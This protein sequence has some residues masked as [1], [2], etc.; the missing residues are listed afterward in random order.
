MKKLK[1]IVNTIIFFTIILLLFNN[2]TTLHSAEEKFKHEKT[3]TYVDNRLLSINEAY[4]KALRKNIADHEKQEKDIPISIHSN[5][6][7]IA[8]ST[9]NQTNGMRQGSWDFDTHSGTLTIHEG[10]LENG[11]RIKNWVAEDIQHIFLDGPLVAAADSSYLFHDL[12]LITTLDL[13][14]L[15]TSNVTTMFSMFGKASSLSNIDVGGWD[16]S[17]VTVMEDMF[18][19]TSSLKSVNVSGWDTSN[20]TT[21]SFMFDGASSLEALD[22]SKWNTSK[23]ES[24]EDMFY[25]NAALTTLDVSNWDVSN[26]IIMEDMFYQASSLTNLN[27]SNWKPSKVITM[28]YMF[29][30]TSSLE[31][32]DVQHWDTAN[33]R[34]MSDM[35]NGASKLTSLDVSH[36]NT[37]NITDF[38]YMFND[39]S[40]LTN[41]NVS[42]WDISNATNME[43]IFYGLDN[44][45]SLDVSDW[46][47]VNLT[48][49]ERMFYQL[50]NLVN[51]NMTG[52]NTSEIV[53]MSYM[54]DGANSLVNLD[55]SGWDTSSVENMS[56]MFYG[57]SSL[58]NLDVGN[59]NTSKVNDMSYLFHGAS[60]LMSLDVSDW[61]ISNVTNLKSIFFDLHE[62][63]SLDVSGWNTSKVMDMEDMFYNASSLITL[64]VDSWNTANVNNMSFMFDGASGLTSLDVSHWDTSNVTDMEDMFFGN[65]SL[66]HLDVSDWDTSNVIDMED[67]FYKNSSLTSLDVTNWNTSKVS[68]MSYMFGDTKKLESLDLSNWNTSKVEDISGIFSNTNRLWKIT[69][70]PNFK[71]HNI[72]AKFQEAPIKGTP[73]YINDTTVDYYAAGTRNWQAI[74]EGS[75]H[76]PAGEKLTAEQLMETYLLTGPANTTTYVWEQMEP[77]QFIIGTDFVMYIGDPIPVVDDFNAAATN[78]IGQKIDVYIDLST[79][80]F[81]T[82]GEYTVRLYTDDGQEMSVKLS[83]KSSRQS[84]TANNFKMYVGND[85]PTVDDFN[86]KATD[87]RGKRLD[88][89]ADFSEANFNVPGEYPIRLYTADDQTLSVKLIVKANQ[90]SITAENFSMYVGDDAPTVADFKAK[91]TDIDGKPI[92]V[93]LDLLDADINVPGEY[94]IR[95]YTADDQTL[96]VK[97]I[98]KANQKSITAENFSMYVGDDVPTV[99]DFK[100]KATDIDG[101]LITVSLDL[102]GA[103]INVPGEYPI[104]LYTAD[105]QTLSVK[106]IVKAKKTIA[107]EDFLM[108]IGDKAP[109]VEDFKAKATNIKGDAIKV[110]LDLSGAKLDTPGEYRVRLYTEDNQEF[111]VKLT[112]MKDQRM[113]FGTDLTITLGNKKP[114]ISDFAVVAKNKFGNNIKIKADWSNVDFSKAGRYMVLFTTDDGQS[115][116]LILNIEN[117]EIND[118]IKTGIDDEINSYFA[119]LIFSFFIL[120]L[121]NLMKKYNH[122]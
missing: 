113:I 78:L 30:K 96:S 50:R 98:V 85:A 62:L 67:M 23:V 108:F 24:M 105:D 76:K 109:T 112:V 88:V 74:G 110:F 38:S 43:R 57:A 22:T 4:A 122:V 17:N 77:Q 80:D 32:L 103:D 104:R 70:G 87:S 6:A 40:S 58:T 59:W 56:Y 52:W 71:F 35:F 116:T 66:Q 114:T 55:V 27:V 82:A 11:T 1:M 63:T 79:V 111:I 115:L 44:L 54:F 15:D 86:P 28:S 39:A 13:R 97:L 102:L 121:R 5:V 100:A 90:K 95:L 21:M 81:N 75:S 89:F 83:V 120:T 51:L 14:D 92:T 53:N 61:D 94:P 119:M 45:V 16:T 31:S 64:D 29:G 93:S 7:P 26:V 2:T 107:G 46:N 65:S 10:E 101:K 49:T 33:V 12:S 37:S 99:A 68:D 41:L 36:W 19:N 47:T 72:D 60:S 118:L 34:D 8:K 117:K 73:V 3:H 106:L 18:Y 20:V 69:L 84:L 9:Q 48:S 25:G 91:A 42:G